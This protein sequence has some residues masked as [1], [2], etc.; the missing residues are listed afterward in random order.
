MREKILYGGDT[1]TGKTLAIYNLAVSY[2]ER[3]VVAF[4]AEGDLDL[5]IEDMGFRPPNL[6]TYNATP[7]WIALKKFYDETKAVLSPDD[8]MCFDM[9]GVFWDLAQESFSQMV[10][11][12]SLAQRQIALL[13]ES[14]KVHF[15]GFD[16]LEHWPTIKKMHNIDFIDNACKWSD[17]NVFATTSL[18]DFSPKETIPKLGFDALMAKEFGKKLAGEKHN[19]YR[20][21]SIVIAYFKPDEKKFYFKILKQKGKELEQPLPEYD[22]TGQS[23]IDRYMVARSNGE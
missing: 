9:M 14:K 10:F 16:G 18:N 13:Q 1:N 7:D 4:D 20:F 11:G 12:Q 2:P 5:T 6:I 8:W 21:R 22:F 19:R 15:E 17:F 23:F 3:K